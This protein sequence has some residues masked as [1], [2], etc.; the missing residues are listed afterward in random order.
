MRSYGVMGCVLVRLLFAKRRV[1][2]MM[3]YASAQCVER[4]FDPGFPQLVLW[5]NSLRLGFCKSS[6]FS[7]LGGGI[8]DFT[9]YFANI[10]VPSVQ[11]STTS[12]HLGRFSFRRIDFE[13]FSA[14]KS[15]TSN[16]VDANGISVKFFK[17]LLPIICC[18]VFHVFN[19]A[20][21]S[22]CFSFYVESSY[23]PVGS[24]FLLSKAF[25]SILHDQVLEHVND[26]NL[27]S[28]F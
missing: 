20:I 11:I 2:D 28:D 9:D 5:S 26:C 3:S 13:C 19:H 6:D 15:I 10:P 12:A 23:Y 18:H 27:L 24:F 8:A 1:A 17:L 7:S 4:V 21:T 14:F 16:A 22:F 25:E